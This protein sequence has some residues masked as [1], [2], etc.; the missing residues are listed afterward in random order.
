TNHTEVTIAFGIDYQVPDLQALAAAD[1]TRNAPRPAP[2]AAPVAA[3]PVVADP[4]KDDIVANN[5]FSLDIDPEAAPVPAWVEAWNDN[6]SNAMILGA[7]LSLLTLIFI[8]QAQLSRHRLAH[9]L[10]RNGFLLIVLVWLGWI[11]GVQ[12]STVHVINYAMAPF[13]HFDIGF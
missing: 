11:A 8:F 7:L 2:A 12:L 10:V 5:D 13:N 9:R 3:A 4:P 6:R 1:D